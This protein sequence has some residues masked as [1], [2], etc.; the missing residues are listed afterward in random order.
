MGQWASY[1]TKGC[2]DGHCVQLRA[3]AWG[4][5]KAG[6]PLDPPRPSVIF[7]LFHSPGG[8]AR[9]AG[10]GVST[11]RRE[12]S[13][14]SSMVLAYGQVLVWVIPTILHS[15]RV[16]RKASALP[17]LPWRADYHPLNAWSV[18]GSGF[19]SCRSFLGVDSPKKND[20]PK[21]TKERGSGLIRPFEN[22]GCLSPLG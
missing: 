8:R 7:P 15:T 9:E 22:E 16:R 11:I 4:C 18:L 13:F 1:R 3:L 20:A 5:E 21:T 12:G 17:C 2:V 19:R 6:P 10:S 14:A